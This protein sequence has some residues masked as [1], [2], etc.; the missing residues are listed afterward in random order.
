MIKTKT[1]IPYFLLLLLCSC[2][3]PRNTQINQEGYFQAS[4]KAKT[5]KNL[6]F[7][8][9]VN[10][11]LLVVEDEDFLDGMFTHIKYFDRIITQDQ[12]EQEIINENRQ[13]ELGSIAGKVGLSRAYRK[14]KKFLYLQYHCY[15]D[16]KS[17]AR[18][19][20]LKLINPNNFEEVFVAERKVILATNQNIVNA[21]L[22]ELIDYIKQN[23]KNY[24]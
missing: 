5:I 2:S 9:D 17:D 16:P 23:S 24:K 19:L 7:D 3:A 4:T 20:Q 12:F 6:A 18:F 21:L 14:Y 8:L 1:L 11:Q 13:E 15:I 10:K 22:N